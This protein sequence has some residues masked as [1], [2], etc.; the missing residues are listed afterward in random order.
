MNSNSTD[1][2]VTLADVIGSVERCAQG[3]FSL[4]QK[5]SQGFIDELQSGPAPRTPEAIHLLE[6]ACRSELGTPS[7]VS[8]MGFVGAPEQELA[9]ELTLL[10]WIKQGEDIRVKKHVLNP[11][12][13]SY[14]DYNTSEW[15]G[16]TRAT[17]RPFIS[18]PYVDSWGTDQ[19][20]ITAAVPLTTQE[21]FIGV[22]AADLDPVRFLRPIEKLLLHSD[23]ITLVDAERRVI[24]S[25]DPLLTTGISLERYLQRTGKRPLAQE[26]GDSINWSAVELP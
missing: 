14:Y 4:L 21:S 20:T 16:T 7:P 24:L 1:E 18:A 11:A 13:D 15:F 2:N 12:S 19:L 25:S 10:W 3:I 6:I 9:Q 17:G 26:T 8:G 23:N 5:T 22:I